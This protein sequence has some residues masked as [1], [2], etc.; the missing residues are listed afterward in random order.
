MRAPAPALGPLPIPT[1][2][3]LPLVYMLPSQCL[4]AWAAGFGWCLALGLGPG[5]R[6][7]RTGP[8]RNC[9]AVVAAAAARLVPVHVQAGLCGM[10]V[11]F[12]NGVMHGSY[13]QYHV[14]TGVM[15]TLP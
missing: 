12:I 11:I 1:P 13:K 10:I 15:I 2:T 6:K 7:H 3:D 4:G 8:G 5:R 14:Q 9:R